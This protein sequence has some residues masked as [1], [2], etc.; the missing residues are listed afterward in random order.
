[1]KKLFSILL[2]SIIIIK[3]FSADGE[4]DYSK[5]EEDYKQNY[6]NQF[7]KNVQDYLTKKHLYKNESAYI[8]KEEF[9][10]IFIDLM[11][12]GSEANVSENFGDTFSGLTQLFVL[13]AFPKGVDKMRGDKIHEYFEY[14]TI[15]KKFDKFVMQT[16]FINDKK[17]K[18]EDL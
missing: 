10:K 1:M 12:G 17:R 18:S 2:I 3:T 4:P 11:S 9:K 7:R 15:M 6:I 14:E 13:D 16:E 8:N 5:F